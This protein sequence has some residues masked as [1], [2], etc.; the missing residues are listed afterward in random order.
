MFW[1]HRLNPANKFKEY[2]E[3]AQAISPEMK[4]EVY[5]LRHRVYCEELG[6]ERPRFDRREH[7]EFDAQSRHL[8]LR[9]VKTGASVGCVRLIMVPAEGPRLPLPFEKVFAAAIDRRKFDPATL[10]R[11]SIAEISR[12]T[13]ACE[14]RRRRRIEVSGEAA[15]QA[16]G[17]P[18]HPTYPYVQ[19]GLYLGAI[20]LAEM[21][22]IATLFL[23]TEPRLLAHFRR[24]G[25]PVRQISVPVQYHG[26]RVLSMMDVV[27]PVADLP[28][29]MRPLY[30]VIAR[31]IE[32]DR[33]SASRPWSVAPQSARLTGQVGP[34]HAGARPP[35]R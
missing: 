30:R 6:F 27:H 2:F 5:R 18:A 16:F 15:H 9:S 4:D 14:F 33:S 32:E 24:L 11:S 22:G 29:F 17:T 26:W 35:F 31:E 20:A 1:L 21:L 10:P 28:F 23:I 12:L 19:L 7:D 8:L 3:L 25:F 34:G 13:L